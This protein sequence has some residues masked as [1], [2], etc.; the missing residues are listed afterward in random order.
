MRVFGLWMFVA[1]LTICGNMDA[2][3]QH[4]VTNSRKMSADIRR[5]AVRQKTMEK[6]ICTFVKFKT[7]NGEKLLAKYG[8][9]KVTQIGNI[10]IA[11]IPT[12]KLEAMADD[13]EVE[14]IETQK[15]GKLMNNVTPQWVNTGD[16]HAGTGGLPQAYDGT[17]V[18]LGII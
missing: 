10:Y 15:G 13:K 2:N 18:L 6:K 14:R 7:D 11:R 3:A 9:E 4:K 12:A 16:I 17:N 1:I 5:A 8:C